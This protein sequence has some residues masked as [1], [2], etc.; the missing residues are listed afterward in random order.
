MIKKIIIILLTLLL[1]VGCKTEKNNQE[2]N[3]N[4]TEE[5]TT[6][7]KTEDKK[8]DK[9]DSKYKFRDDLMVAKGFFS[10]IYIAFPRYDPEFDHG[11]TIESKG[12]GE[13]VYYYDTFIIF[14][15]AQIERPTSLAIFNI[16]LDEIKGPEDILKGMEDQF[17]E[18]NNTINIVGDQTI[19]H[20]SE[21]FI[22]ITK[23]EFITING[24]DFARQEGEINYHRAGDEQLKYYFIAY[25][26]FIDERPVYFMCYEREKADLEKGAVIL[27]RALQSIRMWEEGDEAW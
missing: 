23:E 5:I 12:T 26:T 13:V 21:K 10:D 14:D 24:F 1:L 8:E 11:G 19:N 3:T 2:I 17:I 18:L 4:N 27:D 6:N 25:A 20:K 9:K 15:E 7:D 16:N 22:D